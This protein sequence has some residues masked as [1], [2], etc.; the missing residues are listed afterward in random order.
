MLTSGFG[1]RPMPKYKVLFSGPEAFG[2][3]PVEAADRSDALQRASE[4]HPGCLMAAL[5]AERLPDHLRQHVL[6]SWLKTL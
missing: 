5:E 4:L 3:E 1:V 6:A 2:I